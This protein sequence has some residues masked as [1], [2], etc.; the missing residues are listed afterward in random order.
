M[1][2]VQWKGLDKLT[3]DLN[4]AQKTAVPYAIRSYLTTAAFEARKVWQG[5]TRKSFTLRNQYTERSII[6]V[7]PMGKGDAM[8]S[9]VG[10][11][12]S[13]MGTAEEDSHR[14]ATGRWGIPG[15]AAAG[16][17]PGTKRTRVVRRAAALGVLHVAH[18]NVRG[19]K[20]RRNAAA[21]RLAIQSG[22]GVALLERPGGGKGLFRVMGGRQRWGRKGFSQRALKLRLLWD[23]SRRSVAV[24]GSHTLANTLKALDP[25]LPHM[26]QVALL[27]QLRRHH[28]LGY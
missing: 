10:S 14:S 18:P 19:S 9:K 16:Q 1:L 24:P 3:K 15:A 11:F 7:K 5:E 22:K 27:E 12:A 26:A 13:Y 25:K 6:A 8:H 4:T 28:V 23:V 20:A 17:A 21:I 2:T